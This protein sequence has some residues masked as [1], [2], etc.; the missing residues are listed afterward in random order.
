[1]RNL[2]RPKNMVTAPGFLYLPGDNRSIQHEYIE[3]GYLTSNPWGA[4]PAPKRVGLTFCSP[5]TVPGSVMN[6]AEPV[7]DQQGHFSMHLAFFEESHC[8][9]RAA[10]KRMYNSFDEATNVAAVHITGPIVD[11]LTYPASPE[12]TTFWVMDQLSKEELMKKGIEVQ[13]KASHG[14]TICKPDLLAMFGR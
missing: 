13:H 12:Y 5:H 11:V 7:G 14:M 10:A 3:K 2:N 8:L 4:R 1:M 9:D 6:T